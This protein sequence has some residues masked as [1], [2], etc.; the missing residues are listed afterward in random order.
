MT[1]KKNEKLEPRIRLGGFSDEWEEVKMGDILSVKNGYPFKSEELKEEGQYKIITIKNVQDNYVNEENTMKLSELPSDLQDHQKLSVGDVLISMTGNVG[2]VGI[3]KDDNLLLN[4]RVGLLDPSDTTDRFFISSILTH[5]SFK[6]HLEYSGQGTSQA[7]VKKSDIEEY[8]API[9]QNI[10]E[11]EQIGEFFKKLDQ[12]IELHE[13]LLEDRKLLKKALLQRLFPRNGQTVPE[14]RLGDFEGEWECYKIKDIPS[15][16][17]SFK[18]KGYSKNSIVD[19][20]TSNPIILYGHLFTD[21]VNVVDSVDYYTNEKLDGSVIS[22]RGD[23]LIPSSS[24]TAD[25]SIVKA[26]AI[27]KDGVIL[28]SDINV[29]RFDNEYTNVFLAYYFNLH[30]FKHKLFKDVVGITIRHLYIKDIEEA[31]VLLPS[32]PEQKLIGKFFKNL[33]DQIKNDEERLHSLKLVKK[34]LLQRMFV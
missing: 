31:E 32:L 17:N 22:K 28:G 29:F 8:T 25:D 16:T 11:Q 33:D 14:I 18:G 19:H 2:R 26:V 3:V 5:P 20:K 34:A 24:T 13:G 1:E 30:H 12:Y 9:P 21:Y 10:K 6:N 4:Q 23:L 27:N 15:L 7:N